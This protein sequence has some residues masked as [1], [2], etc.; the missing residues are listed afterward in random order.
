M[1]ADFIRNFLITQIGL[2]PKPL[3]LQQLHDAFGVFRLRIRNIHDHHLLRGQPGRQ[4]TGVV[5]QQD[6]QETLERTQDGT[7]QHHRALARV[8][9]GDV[10]G[11]QA[12][13]QH[14]VKLQ[15][16][17]LPRAADR[18][19]DVV[20]DLGAVEGAL[21]RQL[22]PIHAAGAQRQAQALFGVVPDLVR[23]GTLVR[24]QR[25]LD[26]HVLEAKVVV[27]RERQ[28]VEGLGLRHDLLFRA[29]DV[30]IILHKAAHAHQPVQRARRLVAVAGA[31]L[32]QAQRQV[33][34]RT[35]A[36]VEDLHMARAVHRL[37]RVV[38]LL[39]L[40]DEHVLLVVLPVAGLF[41]KGT[42]HH[43]RRTDFIVAGV[44]QAAAHVL[45]DGLPHLPALR[46]PEHHAGRLFLQVEQVERLAQFAVVALLSLF[47]HVQ[48]GFLVF[49]LRPGRAVDALKH[50]VVGIAAPV[51]A[52]HLHQLEDLQL[53]RGRHVRAA[54]QVD[55]AAFAVQADFLVGGDRGDDLG[56]VLLAHRLEQRHRFVAVPHFAHDPLVLA[57]ELRH[58]LLDGGQVFGREGT[59]VGKVVV[60]AVFDHRPDRHLRFRIQF[61][62]GVGQQVGRG[63]ADHIDAVGI[64]VRD[65]GQLGVVLD[66][67]ARVDQ[68]AVHLAGQRGLGQAGTD[69]LRHFGNRHRARKLAAGPIRQRDCDHFDSPGSAGCALRI[70]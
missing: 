19:L 11:I 9:L 15:R 13:R 8:V 45:L 57:G 14:Q 7:V 17:A 49:L 22:F 68:L 35:Q 20:L 46:M 41:P 26:L 48:V 18:V 66:P 2:G 5:F 27:D 67:M 47:Q 38:A 28:L 12:L 33:A 65:D 23:A 10:F 64:L 59:L 43:L 54:A 6:A 69:A 31:E 3:F 1:L 4:R 37:D 51:G 36:V 34:V 58:L 61:L 16:A 42:I 21:A 40:R 60:E 62:D 24:A 70:A 63:V 29:E 55:E 44:R 32:G 25:Q 30:R 50:L 52:G 56:L 39:R 53:A